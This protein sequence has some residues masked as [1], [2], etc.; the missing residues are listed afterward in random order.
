MIWQD[1]IIT[2]S[3]ILFSYA[4]I[5]QVYK[6]FKMKKGFLTFQTAFLTTIGLYVSA[7][8]FFTL[9]LFFSATIMT[10]NGTLWA[11]LLLQNLVYK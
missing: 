8:A 3:N 5:P 1:I 2:I 4:L 11:I 7:L 10:I 9:N 6:G